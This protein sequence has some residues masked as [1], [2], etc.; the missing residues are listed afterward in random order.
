[1]ERIFVEWSLMSRILIG[2]KQ[3]CVGEIRKPRS[4]LLKKGG[5][6]TLIILHMVEGMA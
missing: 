4:S 5:V 3:V 6:I 2:R 1:M